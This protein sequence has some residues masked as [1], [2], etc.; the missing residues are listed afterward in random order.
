MHLESD[1]PLAQY[2]TLH[3]CAVYIVFGGWVGVCA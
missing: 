3:I 1:P 2:F